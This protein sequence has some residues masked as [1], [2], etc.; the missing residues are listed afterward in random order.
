[1]MK[2][3]FRV[4]PHPLLIILYNE[5]INLSDPGSRRKVKTASSRNKQG[6]DLPPLLTKVN[7]TIHVRT[8]LCLSMYL[9]DIEHIYSSIYL[10]IYLTIYLSIHH[11]HVLM[12]IQYILSTVITVHCV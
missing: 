11:L 4:R 12:Y 10:S 3:S 8:Y 1:M 7:D 6:G 5:F 2:W 9:S